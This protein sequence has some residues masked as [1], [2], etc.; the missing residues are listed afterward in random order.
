[1][2]KA[3]KQLVAV[4]LILMAATNQIMAQQKDLSIIQ[5]AINIYDSQCPIEVNKGIFVTKVRLEDNY[6]NCYANI[7]P[8]D[9][10]PTVYQRLK[11]N[12][13]KQKDLLLV[14][15]STQSTN[16]LY[17]YC[18][19]NQIG[20]KYTYTYNSDETTTL[21]IDITPEEVTDALEQRLPAHSMVEQMVENER[22][23]LPLEIGNGMVETDVQLTDECVMMYFSINENMQDF[24]FL[25]KMVTNPEYKKIIIK[26]LMAS[27]ATKLFLNYMIKDNKGL[28]TIYTGDQSKK[29][30][31]SII[32]VDEIKE[33]IEYQE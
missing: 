11:E 23:S 1:M 31:Q 10:D 5:A 24:D 7:V 18:K 17:K 8:D 3:I 4:A 30:T 33:I 25:E 9:D 19:Q 6:M 12:P 22:S 20:I 14:Y 21:V 28:G 2:K 29:T 13:Q 27:P 16:I 15:L 32:T 26:T